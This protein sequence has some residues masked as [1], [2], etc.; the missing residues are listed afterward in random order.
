MDTTTYT[1]PA[2]W[3]P[4]LVNDDWTGLDDDDN[5]RLTALLTDEQLLPCLSCTEEPFFCTHH[6]ARPWGVLACNCLEFTFP[7]PEPEDD[8]RT[9]PSLTPQQ[10]NPTLR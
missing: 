1:L 7:A 3:A 10:R 4:A 9:H 5:D 8:W 6:D 2:H